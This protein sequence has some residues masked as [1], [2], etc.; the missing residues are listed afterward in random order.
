MSDICP[1]CGLPKDIC[2][3]PTIEKS[4]A[5][6]TI[7][8]EQRKW[9]KKVTI[10]LGLSENLK[11]TTKKLKNYCACGGSRKNNRILLQGDQR[12]KVKMFLEKEGYPEERIELL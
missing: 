12:E 8:L 6:I 11:M 2:A 7:K 3:C 4:Q 1:T 9:G 10:I 5:Q